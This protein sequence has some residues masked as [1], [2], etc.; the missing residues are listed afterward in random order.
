[1]FFEVFV[2]PLFEYATPVWSPHLIKSQVRI[3]ECT[4]KIH[5]A[6]FYRCFRDNTS[7]SYDNRLSQ[8]KLDS[9]ANRRYKFDLV[10]LFKMFCGVIDVEFDKFLLIDSKPKRNHTQYI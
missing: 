7:T 10:F 4:M 5:Q 2:H 9:L 1:M 8:A 6:C 3:R